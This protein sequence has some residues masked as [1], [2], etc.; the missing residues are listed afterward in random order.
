MSTNL[1]GIDVAALHEFAGAVQ[2]DP[3]KGIVQF[4]VKTNWEG[5]TRTVATA[6]EYSIGGEK[7]QRHFE[8]AADEPGELLG[9]NSA[10]NPQEVLMAALNACMSVGYIANAAAM[11]IKVDKLEIQT[12]GQL[13]L[14]G[15]LG[16]DENVKPGYEE[17][18]YT[19]TLRTSAPKEKVEELHRLVMKTS[20]NFSNFAS[21]IRM[22]PTLVV[23]GA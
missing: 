9:K 7:H 10:P 3:K 19:V 12:E 4:N 23:E 17:V 16:L 6:S 1:N 13:D 8:I 2:K 15:F 22:V 21:A 5:Q 11:G 20:P 14:R 18:R